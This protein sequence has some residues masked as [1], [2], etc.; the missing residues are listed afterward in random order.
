MKETSSAFRHFHSC[1]RSLIFFAVLVVVATEAFAAAKYIR[2]GATGTGDGSSWIN[3]YPTF[4]SVSWARGN[5]YYV[6]G[7]IYPETVTINKA[8]SGS[9]YIIVKKANAADNSGDAGWSSSYESATAIIQGTLR[10]F[11]GYVIWDGVTG[12]GAGG[13]G[14]VVYQGTPSAAYVIVCDAAGSNFQIL[15][16]EVRGSGYNASA[17]GQDGIYY[18]ATSAQKGFRVAYCYIHEVTRNGLTVGGLVGTSYADYG[19][20]YEGNYMSE[21]GGCTSAAIHGQG[22]QISY[23]SADAFTIIRDNFF[24]NACGTGMIV[25]LGGTGSNHS[26]AC[27]Y[28]NVFW[29]TDL[30]KYLNCSPGVIYSHNLASS[31]A[32]FYIFNNTVYGV[33]SLSDNKTAH[34]QFILDT[35]GGTGNYMVNNVFENCYFNTGNRGFQTESNNGYYGNLGSVPSATVRQVSAASTALRSPSAQDFS[36]LKSSYA[37]GSAFD[38]GTLLA[39]AG[40]SL[41]SSYSVNIGSQLSGPGDSLPRDI[42]VGVSVTDPIKP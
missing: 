40:L 18:N 5:T 13:Y 38:I 1:V 22:I 24:R 33:G 34:P 21:T 28:D 35:P 4:A 19:M 29:M 39:S 41:D 31:Q 30:T 11:G 6:A 25:W 42:D 26:D 23:A 15:H 2:A 9:S 8:V 14:F 12:S 32:R 3:A 36:I 17:T 7:G 16:T 20:L 37:S 10:L 27:V